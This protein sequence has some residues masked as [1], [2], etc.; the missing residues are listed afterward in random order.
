MNAPFSGGWR[1][2]SGDPALDAIVERLA[3]KTY[4]WGW[5]RAWDTLLAEC[6]NP[7]AEV[8]RSA[9]MAH[10]RRVLNT[11]ADLTAGDLVFLGE[12]LGALSD[13]PPKESPNLSVGVTKP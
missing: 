6:D 2:L 13:A 9:A 7:R 8:S 12:R 11:L 5:P 3:A 1:V 10:R 4:S